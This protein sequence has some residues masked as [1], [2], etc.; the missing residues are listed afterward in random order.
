MPTGNFFN[1]WISI[2]SYYYIGIYIYNGYVK[3]AKASATIS[4]FNKVENHIKNT[5]ALC[6]A[7]G[8]GTVKLNNK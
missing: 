4:Q 2:I 1:N 3:N 8:V 7:K 6:Y 5:F